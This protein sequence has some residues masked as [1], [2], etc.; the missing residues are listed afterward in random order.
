MASNGQEN[1]GRL[2]SRVEPPPA[3]SPVW[4]PSLANPRNGHAEASPHRPG[5]LLK[6]K[7]YLAVST[8]KTHG[9]NPAALFTI[10]TLPEVNALEFPGSKKKVRVYTFISH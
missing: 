1:G 2:W 5:T 9:G 8:L 10:S 3:E 6:A 7:N 4:L